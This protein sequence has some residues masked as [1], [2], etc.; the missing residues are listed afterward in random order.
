[1]RIGQVPVGSPPRGRPVKN[2]VDQTCSSSDLTIAL[3]PMQDQ[4]LQEMARRRLEEEQRAAA[5]AEAAAWEATR[6]QHE[7]AAL[8]ERS[9]ELRDLKQKLQAAEV[10]L[11]RSQQKDQRAAIAAREREYEAAMQAA[12]AAARQEAAAREAAE[13]EARRKQGQEARQGLDAQLQERAELQLV[14]RVGTSW[15]STVV[16]AGSGT[17]LVCSFG[18]GNG[19][20]CMSFS[21]RLPAKAFHL[22]SCF[23]PITTGGV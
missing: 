18:E 6:H 16:G 19:Q 8:L 7:V 14:A 15:C 5:E 21:K 3:H 13:A 12:M 17:T 11:E 2:L 10:N 23:H 20:W 9:A 4:E 22:S 1:M